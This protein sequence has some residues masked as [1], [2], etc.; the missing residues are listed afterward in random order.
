MTTKNDLNL[1]AVTAAAGATNKIKIKINIK[2]EQLKAIVSESSLAPSRKASTNKIETINACVEDQSY[3][4]RK[5]SSR[6]FNHFNMSHK[7]ECEDY[8]DDD[9][10][11][12]IETDIQFS[13]EYENDDDSIEIKSLKGGEIED[14]NGVRTFMNNAFSESLS[15][16]TH[17]YSGG[18]VKMDNSQEVKY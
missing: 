11:A 16:I 4:M 5:L 12:D 14:S 15:S 8:D 9:D 2:P 6:L 3:S 17:A 18:N 7:G 10:D 13:F 1:D